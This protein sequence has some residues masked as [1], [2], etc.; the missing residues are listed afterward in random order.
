MNK[1]IQGD[2]LTELKKLPENSIDCVI[3]SPPYN[4]NSASRVC[5]K[6][7]SWTKA[8]IDY[9]DFKDNLPEKE[10]QEQQK[11][12]LRELVRIIKPTGS[13]FYNHKY[14][15]VNHRV[16]SPE[17]WLNEFIIRQVIIWDRGSSCVL[18]PIRFMP[19]IE[20]IYWI[21]K[22]QTTP[23][24]TSQGFQFKDVW[25]ISPET[26]NDHP[27]PFP[28]EIP[29]RCIVS[30]CPEN[31]V[32]LDPYCGSGTTLLA[33]KKLHRNFIGIENNPTY[34]KIANERLRQQI[35]L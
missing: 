14:R 25:R 7:D 18:E 3:T 23:Y 12:V 8:N 20:Q 2:A 10:Y 33:A 30:A 34:I 24:F 31:G 35:L 26:G 27:A 22:N 13:I 16:I 17:E 1:I 15:I 9:G 21:T 28:L 11:Q 19:T 4:K 5:G 29:E 32:V 6:S